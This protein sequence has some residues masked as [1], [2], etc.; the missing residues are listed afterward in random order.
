MISNPIRSPPSPSSRPFRVCM[1]VD[2]EEDKESPLRYSVS[3]FCRDHQIPFL[4]RKYNT[5]K[6]DEDCHYIRSLPAFHIYRK[7]NNYE[8]TFYENEKP[9]EIL[10]AYMKKCAEQERIQAERAEARELYWARVFSL[11]QRKRQ[12]TSHASV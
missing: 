10:Q 8:E 6:Y 5:I 1:V 4:V 3:K 2:C 12:K 9:F 7:R 11:F